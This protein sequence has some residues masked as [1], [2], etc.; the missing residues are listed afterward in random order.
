MKRVINFIKVRFFLITLSIV[1]IAA[2]FAAVFLTGGYTLGIDF[3]AG[4]NMRVQVAPI[5]FSL[6]Y[7]GG[8]TAAINVDKTGLNINITGTEE[9]DKKFAFLFDKYASLSSLNSELMTIPGITAALSAPDQLDT[10]RLVGFNHPKNLGSDPLVINYALSK[11]SEMNA[12]IAKL[13]ESL[14]TLGIIQLQYVGNK[15]NQEYMVRVQDSGVDKDFNV[16]MSRQVEELL[17][18][19][20][21]ENNVIVKQ[22]DYVGPRFSRNLTQETFYLTGFALLLIL[23]YTWFRFKFAYALGAIVATLHDVCIMLVFIG[24]FKVEVSTAT[25]AAVLTI[26]GYSINDTI[27]VF[28]RIR[29]NT[30]LLRDTQL[31][32]VINISITQSLSRTIITALTTLLAVLAIFIFGTGSIKDFA[33]NLIV[34]IVVGTYSSIYIASPVMLGVT[35]LRERKRKMGD[36]Q[37]PIKRA[38]IEENKSEP[39]VAAVT[40]NRNPEYTI[41]PFAERKLTGKRRKKRK[42]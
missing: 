3:Q 7:S 14:S 38:E 13:R 20:F 28:D 1:V 26:V 40:V 21:G 39:K 6:Q 8:G 11:E 15:A 37:K 33:L 4:I 22:T 34:G 41:I 29:E 10:A 31:E 5:A 18:K 42:K 27:V 35:Y 2:G 17:K 16:N 30:A 12:P 19:S 25:I 9:G 36:E 23:I 24:I 32:T